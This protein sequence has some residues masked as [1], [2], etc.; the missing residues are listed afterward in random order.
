MSPFPI[1]AGLRGMTPRA[2][3]QKSAPTTELDPTQVEILEVFAEAQHRP[4][5]PYGGGGYRPT[6]DEQDE[7]FIEPAPLRIPLARTTW[8]HRPKPGQGSPVHGEDEG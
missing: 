4:G 2:K 8:S 7:W 3:I 5:R 1:L 6:A